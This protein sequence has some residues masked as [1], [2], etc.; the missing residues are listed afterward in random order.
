MPSATPD[1]LHSV[2]AT[3]ETTA[4]QYTIWCRDELF[5]DEMTRAANTME[6]ACDLHLT[7]TYISLDL[8]EHLSTPKTA[9]ALTNELGFVESAHYTL[10]A[11]LYRLATHTDVVTV[12]ESAGVPDV[13]STE[14]NKSGVALGIS[15]PWIKLI[16]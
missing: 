5:T 6:K 7:K 16:S 2:D 10:D 8:A 12:D 1:L 9:V 15:S 11:M 3:S 14:C 13:A 4:D